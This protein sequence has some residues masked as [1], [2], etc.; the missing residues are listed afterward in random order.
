[1]QHRKPSIAGSAIVELFQRFLRDAVTEGR[2]SG[3]AASVGDSH[4]EALQAA[5]RYGAL[6]P[7]DAAAQAAEAFLYA[8]GE[9]VHAR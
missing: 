2:I 7:A 8:K 5:V 9:L 3:S 1:M 4:L 6:A